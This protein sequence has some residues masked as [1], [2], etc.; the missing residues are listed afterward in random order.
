[1]QNLLKKKE[2]SFPKTT[3]FRGRAEVLAIQLQS[4]I[5]VKPQDIVID[6][7]IDQ[8]DITKLAYPRISKNSIGYTRGVMVPLT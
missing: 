8:A 5:I 7:V 2:D 4:A 6:Q 3:E 1:M